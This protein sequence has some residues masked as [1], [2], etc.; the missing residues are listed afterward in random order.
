MVRS[1]R[2]RGRVVGREGGREGG[3]EG[4]RGRERAHTRIN[5]GGKTE[6]QGHFVASRISN[7]NHFHFHILAQAFFVGTRKN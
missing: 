2:E 3:I 1:G 5:I 4:G 6:E 7:E